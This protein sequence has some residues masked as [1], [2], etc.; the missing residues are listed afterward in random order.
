MLIIPVLI[1]LWILFFQAYLCPEGV[2]QQ[3]WPFHSEGRKKK[4]MFYGQIVFLSGD[5]WPVDI[6]TEKTEA[7]V[8]TGD[9]ICTS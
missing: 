9:W 3:L 7:A 6:T 5:F 2:C 4:L 8:K 1:N